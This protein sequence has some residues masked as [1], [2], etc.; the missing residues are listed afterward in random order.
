MTERKSAPKAVYE[1]MRRDV[2]RALDEAV[3]EA[4]CGDVYRTVSN[5]VWWDVY[6]P[7]YGAMDNK[8]HERHTYADDFILHCRNTE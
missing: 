8:H 6:G 7:M 2:Y 4:V 5:A 3:N 1:A